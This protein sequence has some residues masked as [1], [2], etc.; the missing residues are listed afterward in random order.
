[1]Y[2]KYNRSHSLDFR[3][4]DFISVPKGQSVPQNPRHYYPEFLAKFIVF[5]PFLEHDAF[6]TPLSEAFS[7]FSRKLQLFSAVI[8]DSSQNSIIKFLS[9]LET[10][11]SPYFSLKIVSFFQPP[12]EVQAILPT[13][14]LMSATARLR[15]LGGMQLP[16]LL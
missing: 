14:F 12:F 16:I 15:E 5:R 10:T 1:L 8:R 9:F 2:H 7:S 3:R 4:C 6:F 11:L 13:N